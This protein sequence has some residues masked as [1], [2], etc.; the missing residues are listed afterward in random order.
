MI[1]KVSIFAAFAVLGCSTTNAAASADNRIKT[2]AYVPDKIVQIIGKSDIQSTIEFGPDERIE[3]VAVGDSSKWQITPNHRASMLF[4]KPLAPRSRTNMTVVTDQR[5]YMFDLVAGDKWTTPLY[6]LK[7][8]Y[9]NDKPAESPS[10][11][12]Q[13][14]VT[15]AATTVAPAVMTAEKLHFDWKTK[16]DSKLL[17]ARVFDDGQSV[18]LS[19]DRETPLPAILTVSEDRKEGPISYRMSGEYIVISPIPQNLLLRYGRKSAQLW[20]THPIIAAPVRSRNAVA[21]TMASAASTQS[22]PVSPPPAM[23]PPQQ[24]ATQSNTVKLANVG[25]LYSDKLTDTGNEH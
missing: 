8:S 19:W 22:A 18:Y 3:N 20:P 13:P 11:P 24:Q 2:L 21:G 1:R 23:Q 10:K 4:V 17:P 9:P 6:V 25:A 5:T 15:A 7:F 12:E 14:Q 16:G